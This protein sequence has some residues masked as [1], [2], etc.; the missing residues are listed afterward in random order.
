MHRPSG[1][2]AQHGSA[3]FRCAAALL[4]GVLL[5]WVALTRVPR[6]LAQEAVPLA[7]L[8]ALIE[9]GEYATAEAGLRAQLDRQPAA[10]LALARVLFETGRYAEARDQAQL[11]AEEPMQ[12]VAAD[13]LRAE[14]FAAEGQLD[15][16]ELL[17]RGIS[18][19]PAALRARVLLGR[20]LMDRG[21]PKEAEPLLS[22]V[23]AAYNRG[24]LGVD[25]AAGLTYVAMA[26]RALGRLHDANDTFREAAMLDRARVETQLE[27]AQLFLEKYDH[28]HAAESVLA[29]LAQN[30]HS[31]LGHV[32]I[33]RLQLMQSLDFAEAERAL[34][35]ALEDNPQLPA[36]YT[37]RAAMALRNMDIAAADLELTHALAI[38]PNDL[39]ALSVRAAARFLADDARGFAEQERAVLARNPRYS[40]FYSIVAE[41]AE[42]EHRYPE[43]VAM[44][45]RA[46]SI[47]P[48]DALA[49]ATLGLNLLRMGD[50]Q[51][52]LVELHK[53]WERDRFNV[54]VFNTLNLYDDVIRPEYTEFSAKPF[55]IRLHKQERA[56]LEPYLVP[57]LQRAYADMRTRYAFTPEGPLRVELY[58][59][60]AQFS[61][62]T[63]GLPNA[64][65]QGVCFGKVVTGLSPRGGPFNWGQIVWHELSHVFHLQLSKNHVP[66]WFT[67]G[68]A[69]YETVIARPE[70]KR[71]DD[72]ALWKALRSES[73]PPLAAMNRAFTQA[74]RPDDLMTAY[75][76]AFRAVQYIVERFG[77]ASMRP[78]L[79]AF[80][81]GKTTAEVVQSVLGVSLDELDRDFRTQLAQ[82]LEK[83]DREFS[84]DFSAYAD[85]PALQAQVAAHPDDP[86]AL[87]ALAMAEVLVGQFDA[88]ARAGK[89]ALKLAP[90]HRIAHFAIAR[91][92]LAHRDARKAERCLRGIVQSGTDGY[93]L[94]MML[95]RGALAR[96]SPQ[97]AVHEADA[98]IAL[99]P[100]RPEAWKLLLEL[101]T[102][103]GDEALGLR[104]VRAI[105]ELDQHDGLMHTAYL[106]M[107]AKIGAWPDVVREGEVGLFIDPENPALHLHLGE[108]YVQ[109]GLPERGLVE[110]GRALALGYARPGVVH[111][112]RARAYLMLRDKPKAQAEIKSALAQDAS[113][114][115]KVEAL[116]SL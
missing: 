116:P 78:M 79:V 80:G 107:L 106:A 7:P 11:A 21:R 86:D 114:A 35:H 72:Y 28:K 4:L 88:A 16:A 64:G 22:A 20:L 15:Q 37:T 62:R 5:E 51:A 26:A 1:K 87:A 27:W 110:L 30:H 56:I 82:R 75:Y 105:T 49:R 52:G 83:Y 103:L 70:W 40:R 77:F 81:D 17:W 60:K 50:E 61:V 99:D 31:A 47:D 66:R 43:I 18:D 39:E 38:N 91:V 76:L 104:A 55:Q 57:L 3:Q 53:A 65:V 100:D 97:D 92:A 102:R 94:R 10:R 111:L 112:A 108:G 93:L 32:L 67:E 90:Q 36:A 74:R 24:E 33:A 23:L 29:A 8:V 54:Q 13:T 2:V 46:L 89:A 48:E 113:L 45:R 95:A 96:Q 6:A 9:R 59:D 98:A 68:L 58:A 71:E 69:E 41:Y 85:V 109:T 14:A 19:D 115:P 42:W 101:A 84:L 73:L 63:T 12:R 44:A 34:A 25:R